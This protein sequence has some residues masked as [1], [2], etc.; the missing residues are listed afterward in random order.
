MS[1]RNTDVRGDIIRVSSEIEIARNEFRALT[2]WDCLGIAGLI[3]RRLKRM[4]H[5]LTTIA[6]PESQAREH[7]VS[8]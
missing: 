5:I 3:A 4:N 8:R 2:D 6:E 7:G 1:A